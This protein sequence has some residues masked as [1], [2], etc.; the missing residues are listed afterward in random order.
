MPVSHPAPPTLRPERFRAWLAE[1]G[2]E[3]VVIGA[4]G[5]GGR[6]GYLE[7]LRFFAAAPGL[8]LRA[9]RERP[10]L[11]LAG[12][13]LH[14]PAL[15]AI[16]T[17]LGR[18]VVLIADVLG[19]RSI[20]TQQT[21]SRPALRPLNRF[22]WR[23]CERL[24]FRQAD[25]ALAVN[26]R[27]ARLVQGLAP[28]L[29]VTT[30]RCGAEAALAEYEPADRDAVGIPTQAVAVGF[31][32][33]L[34]CS[35]LEPVFAA[36]RELE[37]TVLDASLCLVV[38]GDGPDLERYRERAAEEGWLERSIVFLGGLPRDQA[39]RAL[40][41]CDVAYSEC[42]S[43]HGFP[44]KAYEYLALGRPIVIEGKPQ[45]TEVLHDGHDA[46]FFTNPGEL[47]AALA[48]LATDPHL[49]KRLG[50]AAL[51]T[52]RSAHTLEHRRAEFAAALARVDRRECKTSGEVVE[53]STR[54]EPSTTPR[55][56]RFLS[57]VVPVLN[58]AATIDAQLD[59]LAAQ[60]YDGGWE[61][62]VA[63]NGST[64][65]SL[66]RA[67]AFASSRPWVRVI[68]ASGL[69]SPGHARN[70]GA[71]AAVGDLVLFCDA[72]DVVSSGW[73]SAVAEEARAADLVTG[74][75]DLDRLNDSVA[76][77]WHGT[78]PSDRPMRGHGFLPFASGS[79]CGVW[80]DVFETL[81]GFD[82]ERPSGEDVD[83]SWR[84]Q[85]AG[86]R[87]GFAPDAVVH[88]R[89]RSGLRELARQHF[90]WGRGYAGL[91]R[92]Y[93]SR[94]M[95]RPSLSRAALA[96]GGIVLSSPVIATSAQA[97]GWWVRTAA[98]RSGQVSGSLSE[99]VL[100]L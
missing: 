21:T 8:A 43:D 74:P 82:D 29:C 59:A 25:L 40:R 64:D 45:M 9:R 84:A 17:A 77:A 30:L 19:I 37:Q 24:L 2:Y 78:P 90:C 49:R 72:D 18:R 97:R 7:A 70:E 23:L 87:L 34:V 80:R 83:L 89:L 54:A 3:P 11:V 61:L 12:T 13:A 27:H 53:T 47:A 15:W 1:L 51:E 38:I 57:V 92:D 44:T 56:T 36:W 85:L 26:D 93:R 95:P 62:V 67:R 68:E 75:L 71:R 39:L 65:G 91:F 48:R 28:R 50:T 66:E 86:Y 60:T 81:G 35:R 16:R 100:F 4:R 10:C 52:F 76:R 5:P 63:D 42:W 41:A 14:A 55:Q 31:L 88:K 99:R 22:A 96:W 69:R 32:G 98:E 46:L 94:G 58:A 79:N 6:S 20:E 73:V 33:S